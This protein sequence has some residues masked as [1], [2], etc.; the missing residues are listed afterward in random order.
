MTQ[1]EG[2]G[3]SPRRARPI[4]AAQALT[5]A[6]ALWFVIAAAGQA[7]FAVYI[8]LFYGG[9]TL[10]G[11][12]AAWREVMPDR[13]N[14]ADSVGL[15]AMGVHLALAFVVTAA[16]PLQLIPAIRSRAPA[17]HRWIG[18]VYIALGFIISL[19]GLYLIWG[20][21][22]ADDTLL[23]SAP[24]TLNALLIMAFGGMALIHARARRMGQHRE[25]ALRLFLAMSGVW[26]LRVGIVIWILTVGTAGLGER[27]EGPVGTFL[28]F[29][30]YLA[31]L[32]VLQLYFMAQRSAGTAPKW[33]MAAVMGVLAG[34][35]AAGIG[36]ASVAFWLP[37][38]S[39]A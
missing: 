11:D 2:V 32:A 19:G 16:G 15:A 22:D 20:R 31:P 17:L 27:L 33:A 6:M 4:T 26:F 39:P 18:R 8:G 21:R 1:I 30:C 12:I 35:T 28:K 10:R 5:W 34:G 36:T 24:L 14:P 38:M 23:G 9:S 7:M 3:L 13:A 29:A 37:H 25:W